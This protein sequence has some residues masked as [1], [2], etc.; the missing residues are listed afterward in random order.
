LKK[1]RVK[2]ILAEKF[3]QIGFR[4]FGKKLT[5]RNP[6]APFYPLALVRILISLKLN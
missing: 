6:R 5:K 3:T 1:H 4:G 2:T